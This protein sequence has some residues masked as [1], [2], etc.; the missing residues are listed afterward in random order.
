VPLEGLDVGLPAGRQHGRMRGAIAAPGQQRAAEGSRR[1][2]AVASA[3]EDGLCLHSAS[4]EVPPWRRRGRRREGRSP[5]SSSSGR[6]RHCPPPA[7]RAAAPEGETAKELPDLALF[8]AQVVP[9]YPDGLD[10][11]VNQIGGLRDL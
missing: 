10:D 3:C 9:F 6:R 7:P 1:A 5:R 2:S 8:L 11:L 4:D